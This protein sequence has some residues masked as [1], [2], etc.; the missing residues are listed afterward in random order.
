MSTQVIGSVDS[1]RCFV[2]IVSGYVPMQLDGEPVLFESFCNTTTGSNGECTWRVDTKV[3]AKCKGIMFRDKNRK[4]VEGKGSL[5]VWGTLVRGTQVDE[6]WVQVGEYY[7]PIRTDK[8][9]QVLWPQNVVPV[10]LPSSSSSTSQTVRLCLLAPESVGEYRLTGTVVGGWQS[11]VKLE[12]EA[13]SSSLASMLRQKQ[14][15]CVDLPISTLNHAEF[16]FQNHMKEGFWTRM[17]QLLYDVLHWEYD[18]ENNRTVK[19]GCQVS[20][21]YMCYGNPEPSHDDVVDFMKVALSGAS[22]QNMNLAIAK[23]NEVEQSVLRVSCKQTTRA[24]EDIHIKRCLRQAL[25]QVLSGSIQP[26]PCGGLY[27]WLAVLEQEMNGCLRGLHSLVKQKVLALVAI[28]PADF[29]SHVELEYHVHEVAKSALLE[30]AR[31]SPWLTRQLLQSAIQVVVN[32]AMSGQEV[33]ELKGIAR[34]VVDDCFPEWRAV[35]LHHASCE[36]L[37]NAL[38]IALAPARIPLAVWRAAM[39]FLEHFQLINRPDVAQAC[40]CIALEEA[41]ACS[42]T[43]WMD[44]EDV[45]IWLDRLLEKVAGSFDRDL[46]DNLTL[47]IQQRLPSWSGWRVVIPQGKSLGIL[48][49]A[50]TAEPWRASKVTFQD[51]TEFAWLRLAAEVQCKEYVLG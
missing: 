5:V 7:L 33:L 4:V 30:E 24:P 9:Q 13:V 16:K 47:L 22:L 21:L 17:Q 6:Q 34:R 46:Q 45:A 36:Q 51:E 38:R 48:A 50:L 44:W 41:L 25:S 15:L 27:M 31:L 18:G 35:G 29:M 42:G 14:V 8:L 2:K 1:K 26:K 10:Q 32:G 19:P 20:T 49:R 39:N 40:A 12:C 3:P 23:V 37:E 11:H 28:W 43:F